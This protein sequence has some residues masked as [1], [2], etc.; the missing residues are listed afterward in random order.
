MLDYFLTISFTMM[1]VGAVMECV[2]YLIG[3]VVF[4]VFSMLKGGDEV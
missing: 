2:V 1:C 3:Y 4:A